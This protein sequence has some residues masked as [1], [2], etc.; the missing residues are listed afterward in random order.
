M[1]KAYAWRQVGAPRGLM[2]SVLFFAI[3]LTTVR[4]TALLHIKYRGADATFATVQ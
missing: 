1:A 3:Y 4:A 2:V